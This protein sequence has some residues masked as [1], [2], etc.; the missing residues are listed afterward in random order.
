M[1]YWFIAGANPGASKQVQFYMD[2]DSDVSD[3]P[4]SSANGVKQDGDDVSYL[5]CGKGSVALSIT[6]GNIFILDSSDEW[7]QV[8]G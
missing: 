8:G 5:P 3:L 7:T 4:T 6:T 2:S 1:A